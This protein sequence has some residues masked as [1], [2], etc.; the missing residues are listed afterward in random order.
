MD[1]CGRHVPERKGRQIEENIVGCP[2][3]GC[4]QTFKRPIYLKNHMK[5]HGQ[6]EMLKV[7][8]IF[9]KYISTLISNSQS[10]LIVYFKF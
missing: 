8:I 9:Y 2:E 1:A 5:S 7:S 6:G 4:N 3:E 10:Y